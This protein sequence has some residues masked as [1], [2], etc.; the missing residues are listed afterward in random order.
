M[1]VM[2]QIGFPFSAV[3]SP[4]LLMLGRVNTFTFNL[5]HTYL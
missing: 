5:N 1:T 2:V 3:T 4:N